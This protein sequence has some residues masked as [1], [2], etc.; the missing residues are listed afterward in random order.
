MRAFGMP[1][2]RKHAETEIWN[3]IGLERQNMVLLGMPNKV[4]AMPSLHTGIAALVAFYAISRLRSPAR[5]LLL[6]YPAAMGLALCYFGEHYVID[7][8][9]GA[10]KAELIKPLR[11]ISPLLE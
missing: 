2:R 7:E 10:S 9:V 8:I 4:A 3:A 1:K 11:R 5:W 6:L